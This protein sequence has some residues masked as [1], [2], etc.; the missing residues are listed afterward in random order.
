MPPSWRSNTAGV[1][2]TGS[3]ALP[4]LSMK[5][6]WPERSVKMARPSGRKARPQGWFR[7]RTKVSTLKLAFWVV[8]SLPLISGPAP[9]AIHDAAADAQVSG[10]L[11][12]LVGEQERG[13]FV[14]GG[15]GQTVGQRLHDLRI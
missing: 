15:V 14:V 8:K 11:R 4:F 9:L 12:H 1:P 3:E 13:E 6:S 2:F 7:P 10:H 5:R